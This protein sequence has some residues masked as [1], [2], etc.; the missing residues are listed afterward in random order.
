MRK[1]IFIS[2]SRRDEEIAR[3]IH[4]QLTADGVPEELIF[5]DRARTGIQQGEEWLRRIQDEAQSTRVVL[6]LLSKSFRNSEFIMRDELPLLLRQKEFDPGV[7]IFWAKLSAVKVPRMLQRF[8]G[9]GIERPVGEIADP[10]ERGEAILKV[11]ES[12]KRAQGSAVDLWDQFETRVELILRREFSLR[13]GQKLADGANSTVYLAF[14][15]GVQKV[16]KAEPAPVRHNS[17]QITDEE[18]DTYLD[19]CRDLSHPAFIGFDGGRISD[20]VQVLVSEFVEDAQPL[21]SSLEIGCDTCGGLGIDRVRFTIGTLANALAEYHDAGLCYGTI[22]PSDLLV[23]KVDSN[24]WWV[25][26]PAFRMSLLSFM[27]RRH[28]SGFRISDEV[29]TYLAPEQHRALRPT[30]K[31]D[32]Y[33]LALLGIELLQG[34]PPVVVNSLDDLLMKERFFADPEGFADGEGCIWQERSPELRQHL[35]RM[36]QRDPKRRFPSLRKVADAFNVIDDLTEDNRRVAKESFRRLSARLDADVIA[37]FFRTFVHRRSRLRQMFDD[38]DGFDE[39]DYARKL[40]QAILF[41]LNFRASDAVAE[42][43]TLYYVRKRHRSLDLRKTDFDHFETCLLNAVSAAGESSEDVLTA[44][45]CTIR[46]GID[47][48]ADQ[49]VG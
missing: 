35:L 4:E 48:M 3:E 30:P 43:T 42:P 34:R 24:E 26:L 37:P 13:L 2:Y 7:K 33:S 6:F 17:E 28:Q 14:G 8:Q 40:R 16:A 46:P 45:R 12:V 29:M 9:Y 20:D 15:E 27:K 23:P 1:K 49:A 36:L 21:A 22:R 32:Q 47:Y 10:Q 39:A 31:S 19:R 5:F 25:R 44:W 11:T 41:L 38:A 18:L